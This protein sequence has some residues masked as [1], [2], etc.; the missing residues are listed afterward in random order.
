MDNKKRPKFSASEKDTCSKPRQNCF[1]NC[2]IIRPT[3]HTNDVTSLRNTGWRRHTPKVNL[4]KNDISPERLYHSRSHFSK[5]ADG[6]RRSFFF[7]GI[8]KLIYF[9]LIRRKQKL[10][11]TVTLICW[12]LPYCPNDVD[13]IRAMT[14]NSCKTVSRHTAQKWRNSFYDRTLQTS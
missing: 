14:L 5:K 11:R 2:T 6:Q 7:L 13:I 8:E 9:S 12:R 10:T 1:G 3:Y 4:S